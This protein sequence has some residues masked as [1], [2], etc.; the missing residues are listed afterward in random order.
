MIWSFCA[1]APSRRIMAAHSAAVPPRTPLRRSESPAEA[2][3]H[4]GRRHVA[5]LFIGF[6]ILGPEA[7]AAGDL[8]VGQMAP[9]GEV[10]D[11]AFAYLPA[12]GERFGRQKRGGG[13]VG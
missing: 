7:D 12:G 3:R 1:A 9:F 11:Q 4:D 5:R 6:H 10:I 8:D 13:V 2:H